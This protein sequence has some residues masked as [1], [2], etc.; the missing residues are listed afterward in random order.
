MFSHRTMGK[1]DVKANMQM[2]QHSKGS[3][4]DY[5]WP[6]LMEM[7]VFLCTQHSTSY[8][9]LHCVEKVTQAIISSLIS[10]AEHIDMHVSLCEGPPLDGAS[11]LQSQSE[12]G[13][14]DQHIGRN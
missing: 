14:E 10:S 11:L 13:R 4:A 6:E 2:C 8:S 3:A 1:K 9:C 12:R 7:P 5:E